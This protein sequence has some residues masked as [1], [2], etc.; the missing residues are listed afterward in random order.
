MQGSRLI[1]R[2]P[3]YLLTRQRT[4]RLLL[5]VRQIAFLTGSSRMKVPSP[6][7]ALVALRS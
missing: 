3:S 2:M 5:P 4:L 7:I 1:S 6:L